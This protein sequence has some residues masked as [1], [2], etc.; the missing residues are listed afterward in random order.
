MCPKRAIFD[1]PA[2]ATWTELLSQLVADDPEERASALARLRPRGSRELWLLTR[3]GAVL[4]LVHA[5]ADPDLRVR[6]VAVERLI[7]FRAVLAPVEPL[8]RDACERETNPSLRVALEH[9]VEHLS[10]PPTW[11]GCAGLATEI[12]DA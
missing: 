8:I 11:T 12:A 1:L 4:A 5:A 6:R 9:L 7:D 10:A 2:E 3:L